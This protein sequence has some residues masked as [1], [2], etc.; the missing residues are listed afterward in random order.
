M[1]FIKKQMKATSRGSPWGS[2]VARTESPESPGATASQKEGLHSEQCP[3]RPLELWGPPQTFPAPW[4]T[5]PL[6]PRP[7]QCTHS[8]PCSLFLS[9]QLPLGR[10]P[11]ESLA[12][13][14]HSL[15]YPG[16]PSSSGTGRGAVQW[17][18]SEQGNAVPRRAA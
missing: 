10:E 9:T 2:L 11:Q 18:R 16:V 6:G 1:I 17:G 5:A 12:Y 4:N 13:W 14:P 8:W 15:L 7:V 3:A